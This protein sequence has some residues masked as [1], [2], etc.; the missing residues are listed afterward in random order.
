M[1]KR[2]LLAALASVALLAACDKS[3]EDE[4]IPVSFS[5]FGFYA[6]DNAGVLKTDYI[7]E[8]FNSDLISFTLLTALTLRRSRL[9]SLSSR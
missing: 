1:S 5:S 6:K 9:S 4:V 3:K 7:E 8:S 2:T